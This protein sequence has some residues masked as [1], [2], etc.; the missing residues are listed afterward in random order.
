MCIAHFNTYEKHIS[1]RTERLQRPHSNECSKLEN[2]KCVDQTLFLSTGTE[3]I[4]ES[5]A[6]SDYRCGNE[7]CWG[8]VAYAVWGHG[9]WH[10]P[11]AGPTPQCGQG[12]SLISTVQTDSASPAL[13][14][15]RSL[16]CSSIS[17]TNFSIGWGGFEWKACL[18]RATSLGQSSS[19]GSPIT[20]QKNDMWT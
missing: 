9:T 13:T 19:P 12:K 1:R 4:P 18:G 14:R 6:T 17:V 5:K 10:W 2:R 20:L 3:D 7:S 15:S 8:S 11:D 16:P